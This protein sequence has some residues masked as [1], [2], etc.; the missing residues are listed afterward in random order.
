MTDALAP[1]P[2]DVVCAT[3]Y[4]GPE[5]ARVTGT[6]RGRPVDLELSRTDACRTA[7]WDRLGPLLT[8]SS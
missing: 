5:T 4:G 6:V 8:T 1:L 7:Q 2:S 3:V